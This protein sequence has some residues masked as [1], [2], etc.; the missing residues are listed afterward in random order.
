[1]SAAE[2]ELAQKVGRLSVTAFTLLNKA[3]YL[4][5]AGLAEAMDFTRRVLG[6]AMVY[7]LSARAAL[8][9]GDPGIDAFA[10]DFR[11]YLAGKRVTDLRSSAVAQARRIAGALLDEVMLTRRAVQLAA[12]DAAK[13]VAQF[14][15]RL[16]EVAVRG[17]DAV[18]VVNAESARQLMAL[19]DAADT[20]GPR[21][22]RE[23]ARNWP[24][25]RR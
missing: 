24:R 8:D 21:L 18:T 15:E 13:R 9:R 2:R 23:V 14:G 4:D 19:N 12:G 25:P 1:M 3:D 7:P 10:A 6:N 22:G 20:D 17:R 11:R 5:E 16:A